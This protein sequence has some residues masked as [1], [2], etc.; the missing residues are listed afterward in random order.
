MTCRH[1]SAPTEMKS[2]VFLS[3]VLMLLYLIAIAFLCFVSGDS[4]PV[5]RATFLGFPSDKVAHFIMFLPFPIL[6][7]LSTDWK[8]TKVWKNALLIFCI[9]IVGCGIASLTEYIQSLTPTRV[10]DVK[11]LYADIISLGI[12]SVFV[13]LVT[14]FKKK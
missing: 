6:A 3:R 11:D 8:I 2:R 1:F 5:I 7:F 14:L 9:L 12:S 4:I 10:G 13:F